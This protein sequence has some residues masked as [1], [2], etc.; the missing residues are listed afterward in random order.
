MASAASKISSRALI[1]PAFVVLVSSCAAPISTS[2]SEPIRPPQLAEASVLAVMPPRVDAGSEW[3]KP[4]AM[5]ALV[6]HL[7]ER[8][9]ETTVI[10]PDEA[11]RRLAAQSM[12]GEYASL[13]GDFE[14]AGVVDPGRVEALL[15]VLGASHLLYLQTGYTGENLQRTTEYLDGTPLVYDTRHHNLYAVARLWNAASSTP[16]W[17]AVARV[18]S[19]A[20]FI[21][22]DRN[23]ADLVESLARS[24]A[25]RIPL[26]NPTIAEAETS[27]PGGP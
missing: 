26:A 4:Q 18:Q 7:T 16:S 27:G 25:E 22:R 12:A 19:Q 14:R 10:G 1:I 15:Q 24:L 9:K 2:L 13:L 5:E 17:E 11:G 20:D 6:F 21:T 3:L 23:P 8:F